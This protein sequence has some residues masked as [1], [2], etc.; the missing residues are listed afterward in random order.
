MKLQKYY[1]VVCLFFI[2]FCLSCLANGKHRTENHATKV[3]K[4]PTTKLPKYVMSRALN[5]TLFTKLTNHISPIYQFSIQILKISKENC[6]ILMKIRLKLWGLNLY[7]YNCFQQKM[8]Y[9][10]TYAH[11]MSLI[12]LYEKVNCKLN[13]K[14]TWLLSTLSSAC[15]KEFLLEQLTP[16]PD[17]LCNGVK[18][19]WKEHSQFYN[20]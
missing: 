20:A 1:V 5:N 18:W 3:T 13:I 15:Q 19:F 4:K 16:R 11:C 14:P 17:P 6:V 2:S 8:S 7:D 12:W 9:P 10:N